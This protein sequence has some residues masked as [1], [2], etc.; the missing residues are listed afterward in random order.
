[1]EIRSFDVPLMIFIS[2]MSYSISRKNDVS[3]AKYFKSRFKRL[4]VPVWIFLSAFYIAVY[5]FDIDVYRDIMNPK[6]ILS[7]Y[8][9]NGF[10]YVWIVRVFLLIAIV[11]PLLVKVSDSLTLPKL[12][13]TAI[14]LVFVSSA[15]HMLID[16]NGKI[17]KNILDGFLLPTLSYSS[18]FMIG[19][20]WREI[21]KDRKV[22]MLI[23]TFF[24][25]CFLQWFVVKFFGGEY[26]NPNS[27][28]YPPQL[29][30]ICY[31]LMMS[32]VFYFIFKIF[33]KRYI[34]N[35]PVVVFISSNTIWIYLWHIPIV[36]FF[37]RSGSDFPVIIK[38]ILSFAIPIL[39][40]YAQV[41]AVKMFNGR[42]HDRY[43]RFSKML[44]G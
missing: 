26:F 15:I 18:L 23:S 43:K 30:Y 39:V 27:Y 8:I 10:G 44:T 20:K 5:V 34:F 12:L 11:S 25:F 29:F 31:G 2:G 14:S 32:L 19:Y 38:Y 35:L 3:Y 42:T 9:L 16:Y 28:K 33:S 6:I 41:M 21:P 13:L 7:S 37:L 24:A 1:M 22:L 4:V 36:E 40:T 17:S